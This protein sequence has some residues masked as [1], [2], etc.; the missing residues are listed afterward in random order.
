[1][2]TLETASALK[3]QLANITKYSGSNLV[4]R[5]DWGHINFEAARTDIELVLSI[6]GDLENMPV[7]L[8]TENSA[9]QIQNAIP[10]VERA[11]LAIDGFRLTGNV[12]ANRD[13]CVN[14]LRNAAETLHSSSAMWIPYLA[15][16]RGD[17]SSNLERLRNAIADAESIRTQAKDTAAEQKAEVDEIVNAARDA[18]AEAGVA[19]F[20]HAFDTEA[21][22]VRTTSR[23]WL[24]ATSIGAITTILWAI[25]SYFWPAPPENATAWDLARLMFA[26]ISVV[27]VLI[28]ATVWCG[29]M[30]RAL[31]H[32]QA[33]NRH[34]ALGLQTFQAFTAATGDDQ[35]KNAVLLAATN[36]I[37]DNV[38]TGLADQNSKGDT[39]R[40]I[41][42]GT[43]ISRMA[44]D[45]VKP[46]E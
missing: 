37:F 13:S 41:G 16:R 15:F 40:V 5:P 33:V 2:A 1:M 30:Y 44:R 20:T 26:K 35:T 32:Q 11:L 7:E 17:V 46:S 45:S 9:A 22:R 34:R 39:V 36:S 23:G 14:Q 38:P 29:R 21:N 42:L 6:A 3:A 8:L 24:I 4:D 31:K 27:V 18:A 19:T 43:P 10:N 28:T 25:I 12:E